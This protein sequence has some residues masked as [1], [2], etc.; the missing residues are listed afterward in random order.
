MA[1]RRPGRP[2]D[3]TVELRVL[4]ATQEL[5]TEVGFDQLTIDA[6][7]ERCGISRATIYRRW[8]D[9]TELVVAAASL[10]LQS[11]PVPETGDLRTDLL[12]CGRA[13]VHSGE[14][15]QRVLVALL[16][17][18]PNHP[19][20]RTVAIGPL[21]APYVTLFRE[22]FKRA[23]VLGLLRTGVDI[24]LL[25]ST[26]SALAFERIA[27]YGLAIDETFVVR[28]V[29]GL[30]IPACGDRR[31]APPADGFPPRPRDA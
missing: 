5:L 9:K 21:A 15:S 8:K 26:F 6:V 4:G 19:E 31:A 20:L 17:A 11:P 22:V 1:D 18:I 16:V 12:E 29:D 30:L 24:D 7:A 28:V 23:E 10:L 14:K 13:F 27:G 2:R 25:A 3:A